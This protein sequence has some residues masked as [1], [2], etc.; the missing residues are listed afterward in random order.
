MSTQILDLV[1]NPRPESRTHALARTLA[2]EL[3]RV[4]PGSETSEVD[5]AR[6]GPAVLDSN[7][8]EVAAV[9]ERVLAADVLVV[10]SPTYKATYSG[11][12]TGFLDRL[13]NSRPRGRTSTETRSWA[14]SD[15]GA[16]AAWCVRSPRGRCRAPGATARLR[17]RSGRGRRA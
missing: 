16:R 1:G 17:Q 3:A 12:L 6:L 4:I 8:S 13:A 10:A 14:P 7:E 9:V 15:G 2:A 11:L 5:L